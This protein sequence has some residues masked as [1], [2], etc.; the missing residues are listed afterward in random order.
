MVVFLFKKQFI[1]DGKIDGFSEGLV[2]EFCIPSE[3]LNQLD[4][5]HIYHLMPNLMELA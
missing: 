2:K 1:L 3:I 4:D 5:L